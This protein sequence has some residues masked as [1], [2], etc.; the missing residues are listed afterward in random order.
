M[1]IYAHRGAS[2]EH[3]ENTLTAFAR[4]V[5]LGVE[6]IELDIHLSADGVPVVLHDETLDRTTNGTGHVGEHTV[7]QLRALD[8]GNG[9]Y[10]PTL[11]E[12]LAL[13]EGKVRVNIEIKDPNV[14]G[15]M[16]AVV[17]KFPNLSWFASSSVWAALEEVRRLDPSADTYP[18][19]YGKPSNAEVLV[20]RVRANHPEAEAS[21]RASQSQHG[22]LEQAIE[23]AAAAGGSGVSIWENDLSAEDLAAVHARGLEAWVWTIN[24]AE[25]GARVLALGIDAVCTDDPALMQKVVAGTA[26]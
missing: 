12:V 14:S 15:P 13:A 22:N 8:A 3:P 6:G 24:G 1:E 5:E 19:T 26:P 25:H 2:L 16:L 18:L 23:F 9:D 7:E 20:E 11:E 21:V 17:A 10:V 4:A